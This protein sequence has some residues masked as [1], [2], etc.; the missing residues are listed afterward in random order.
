MYSARSLGCAMSLSTSNTLPS[1]WLNTVGL[2]A[3]SHRVTSSRRCVTVTMQ[4]RVTYRCP[5]VYLAPDEIGICIWVGLLLLRRWR[6][7][8]V[9]NSASF[10][11]SLSTGGLASH[12]TVG[13]GDDH[14]Q[15]LT[16]AAPHPLLVYTPTTL[17]PDDWWQTVLWCFWK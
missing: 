9:V 6:R 2:G 11:R 4:R 3:L 12:L 7:S 15:Q 13:T 14:Y 8:D 16:E 5:D 10:D 1:L 17:S